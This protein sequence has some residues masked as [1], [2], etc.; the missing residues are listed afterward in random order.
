MADEIEKSPE[1]KK[2][3]N[4]ESS[5]EAILF[6]SSDSISS[7]RIADVLGV[8]T[9]VIE[10]ALKSMEK[11]FKNR[12]IRIQKSR[13]GYKFTTAPE[14]AF[15]IETYLNLESTSKLTQAALETLAIVAYQQPITRPM[16]DA[17][18]GVNSDSV[19]KTLLSKGLI[20]EAGRS[21]SPG[22][23]ILYITSPEFLQYFGLSSLKDL[24]TLSLPEIIT[25]QTADQPELP[26]ATEILKE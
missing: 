26:L 15:I 14:A 11:D 24:P 19:I 5:I 16:I 20:E 21:E 2:R 18:R 12:G 3:L 1:Q 17:V 23:P 9:R 10:K 22:R 8:T 4:L 13:D 6:V 7:K 25:T